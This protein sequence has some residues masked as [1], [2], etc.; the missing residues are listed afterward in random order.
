M[1]VKL[2]CIAAG[3]YP[4]ALVVIP[5]SS[6]YAGHVTTRVDMQPPPSDN[7]NSLHTS[8]SPPGHTLKRV[9]SSS[10]DSQRRPAAPFSENALGDFSFG[11]LSPAD[12][13]IRPP[14]L[15]T[16]TEASSL[17]DSWKSRDATVFSIAD[18]VTLSEQLIKA[19]SAPLSQLDLGDDDEHSRALTRISDAFRQ[20]IPLHAEWSD[21]DM[22]PS[23]FL[24]DTSRHQ[25]P[26]AQSVAPTDTIL[27][28]LRKMESEVHS[29][30]SRL[31]TK[32]NNASRPDDRAAKTPSQTPPPTLTGTMSYATATAQVPQQASSSSRPSKQSSTRPPEPVRFV[33]RFHGSPP[34]P[35]ERVLPKIISDNINRELASIP[36]A[37][38][39][40]VIG[41]HWNNSGNCI[42][43]FPHHT[44]LSLIQDHLPSIRKAMGLPAHQTISHDAPWSKI[45]LSGVFARTHRDEPV[46]TGE[47][48]REALLRNPAISRLNITQNPRWV[49]PS[50][51]I[52]GFKSSISFAFEDPD[53]SN[54]KS[55]LKTNLF[56]FGAPVRAKRWVEKPRLR[57]CTRCWRLGHLITNCR[58]PIRCRI[59]GDQHPEDAH[60][61]KCSACRK[62]N[63]PDSRACDHPAL[64]VNCRGTHSADAHDCPERRK[65]NI[66]AI[67]TDFTLTPPTQGQS[68]EA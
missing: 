25:T 41:S 21:Y 20:H 29:R 68:M 16:L 33:V 61:S 60:R 65:F 3:H 36:T 50:E 49:R 63:R 62:E 46:Y 27:Q 13:G 55:L 5:V 52:D 47:T 64:C 48:L 9:R 66:P 44:K 58:S 10:G 45:I 42:L 7:P 26:N 19:I 18:W 34:A 11:T 12:L 31:E 4:R 51:F 30:L 23:P 6:I 39:L 2:T 1:Y 56:M 43:T 35:A 28:M 8:F 54:L 57:Q 53:G 17:I 14:A 59:C 22:D 40:Q 37:K 15:V 38:G 24:L 67:T 32:L